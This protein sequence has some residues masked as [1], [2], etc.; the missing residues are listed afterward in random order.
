MAI[1]PTGIDVSHWSGIMDWPKACAAGAAFAIFKATDFDPY[2]RIGFKDSQFENNWAGTVENHIINGCYHWLQPGI[3]ASTQA[4][5]FLEAWLMNP[6]NLPPILDLEDGRTTDFTGLLYKAQTWLEQVEEACGR[7]PMVYTSA[8]FM[9]NFDPARAGFLLRYPLW[10]AQYTAWPAPKVPQPWAGW[11]FWQY[12]DRG[13]GRA[14]GAQ[15][16]SMDMNRFNGTPEELARL[17]GI[18]A[19]GGAEG[20]AEEGAAAEAARSAG[21]PPSLPA[22]LFR[23]RPLKG[24]INIRIGPG[25]NYPVVGQ[26]PAGGSASVLGLAGETWLRLGEGQYAAYMVNNVQYMEWIPD[27]KQTD[28]QA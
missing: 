18:A 26:V 21:S 12:S 6:C 11:T 4:D 15:S 5:F 27:G 23:V 13:P 20:S 16:A 14:Y 22:A 8:G 17:A 1:K 2:N 19:E 10:L 3:N 9:R 24:G 7:A 25:L 28:Q